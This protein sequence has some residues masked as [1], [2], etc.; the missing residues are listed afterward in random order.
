MTFSVLNKS[1]HG[2]GAASGWCSARLGHHE[3][4]D[5]YV[6][7]HIYRCV[8]F[9]LNIIWACVCHRLYTG[10]STGQWLAGPP[11]AAVH[12]AW[13]RSGRPRPLRRLLHRQLTH[14][15]PHPVK[16]K[17]KGGV[18]F[19]LN[20]DKML[21]GE[22]RLNFCHFYICFNVWWCSIRIYF[23]K[24]QTCFFFFPFFHTCYKFCFLRTDLQ[25]MSLTF[26]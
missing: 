6:L 7:R 21:L 10:V 16:G 8:N 11:R 9:T 25:A 18:L 19:I 3:L 14:R 13:G 1:S 17:S 23:K 26:F 12:R 24:N 15:R 5:L 22:T 20:Y 4:L 2:G